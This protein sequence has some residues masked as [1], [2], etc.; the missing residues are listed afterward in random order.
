L[1]GNEL[2][3]FN[4]HFKINERR[5]VLVTDNNY[6]LPLRTFVLSQLEFPDRTDV[7]AIWMQQIL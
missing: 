3:C 7:A 2:E 6:S 1:S 5:F 4:K